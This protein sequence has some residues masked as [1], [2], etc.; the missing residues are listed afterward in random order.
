VG[1]LPTKT[2]NGF[3]V[4]PAN[5]RLMYAAMRDG[6]FRS[7]DAGTKWTRVM[8]GPKNVAAVAINPKKPAE[9]YA[10]T[11]DGTVFRSTDAGTH[12]RGV[13]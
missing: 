4:H 5:P 8:H 2:V 11:T 13:R 12:W 7:D 3:A 1:G 10:V 9:V 6:V